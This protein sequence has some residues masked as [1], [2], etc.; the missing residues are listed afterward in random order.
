MYRIGCTSCTLQ[1]SLSYYS[2]CTGMVAQVVYYKTL[3]LTTNCIGLVRLAI[4][5]KILYIEILGTWFVHTLR[6][7]VHDW[8]HY[9]TKILYLIIVLDA[10]NTVP[11]NLMYRIGCTSCT[12]LNTLKFFVPY[13]CLYRIRCTTLKFTLKLNVQ[14]L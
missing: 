11:W 10:Q 8:L 13:D 3:N 9:T 1:N 5:Y 2:A 4:H 6:F 12:M 7:F 14:D